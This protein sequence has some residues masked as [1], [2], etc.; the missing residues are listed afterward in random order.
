M[1]DLVITTQRQ[2]KA[3]VTLATYNTDWEIALQPFIHTRA[4]LNFKRREALRLGADHPNTAE[5]YIIILDAPKNHYETLSAFQSLQRAL[6]IRGE[7]LGDNH[8]ITARSYKN[9]GKTAQIG[10]EN[11][12]SAL[13][14]LQRGLDSLR[15]ISV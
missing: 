7:K 13:H 9:S 11:Y 12:T 15:V 8:P 1:K 2:L 5:S 10:L 6:R 14:L 3:T 4:H